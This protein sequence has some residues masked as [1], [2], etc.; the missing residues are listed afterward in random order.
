[1]IDLQ[2]AQARRWA[3]A[4][5][6]FLAVVS[7]SACVSG[8]PVS[9]LPTPPEPAPIPKRKPPVPTEFLVRQPAPAPPKP[10]I[11]PQR[12]VATA[13]LPLPR[14]NPR[15]SA[16]QAQR[17]T[18]PLPKPAPVQ[19]AAKRQVAPTQQVPNLQAPP[20]DAGSYIVQAGEN[21]FS[22]ARKHNIPIRTLLEVNRLG[23]PYKL[24]P[25]R[26]LILPKPSRHIV[27]R[28]ETVYAISRRYRIDIHS[29][30]QLNKIQPPF[31]ISV[32]QVLDLPGA[33]NAFA[34]ATPRVTPPPPTP[35]A[36]PQTQITQAPSGSNPAPVPAVK[37]R[38]TGT[39]AVA[40]KPK[41]APKAAPAAPKAQTQTARVQ[42]PKPSRRPAAGVPKP[43]PRSSS[44]FRWPLSGRI[45][46]SYGSKGSGVHND[47]INIEAA[48][49]TI[50]R[51]AENGVI[52]Y[53]GNELR[54]F[55][56]LLLIRHADGWVTAYA[57]LSDVLVRRGDTVKRGQAVA[58]VGRTG[59]V[60]KPQLHFEIRQGTRAVDPR[61]LLGPQQAQVPN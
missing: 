46:S 1:M 49:G 3:G 13:A 8:T 25:G 36:T 27:T 37:P 44:K 2:W 7:L 29:L 26:R 31:T 5:A 47:G 32:G 19:Q 10:Y 52:A 40:G 17:N 18:A 6:A 15:P 23:P 14:R 43:P 34:A 53:S 4:T 50:V 48:A 30:V 20:G 58:K 45:L 16:P 57:H 22:I 42:P 12:T 51:A 35:P 56:R 28:G 55:G 54:G 9:Q 61:K 24:A 11:A 60:S 21:V 39:T 41:T 59:N 38:A 33:V